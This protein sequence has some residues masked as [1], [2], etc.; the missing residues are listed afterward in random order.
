MSFLFKNLK[1]LDPNWK[2]SRGGY[3]APGYATFEVRIRPTEVK[4]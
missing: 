4:P 2:E 1:L 3:D